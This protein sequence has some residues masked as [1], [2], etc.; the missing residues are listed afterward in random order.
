MIWEGNAVLAD[1]GI[2]KCL[3]GVKGL[4]PTGRMWYTI[5]YRAPELRL[6]H[7]KYPTTE[8]DMYAFGATVLEVKM[9]YLRSYICIH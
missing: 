2:A 9:F 7:E 5:A 1:F 3:D 4:T 6:D 8:S